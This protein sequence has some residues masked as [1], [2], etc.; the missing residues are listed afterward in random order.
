MKHRGWCEYPQHL[1]LNVQLKWLKL[2]SAGSPLKDFYWAASWLTMDRTYDNLYLY[3]GFS[4]GIFSLQPCHLAPSAWRVILNVWASQTGR[5][6]CP[7]IKLPHTVGKAKTKTIQGLKQP[8]PSWLWRMIL[9]VEV[10]ALHGVRCN[11][12]RPEEVLNELVL[13]PEKPRCS[14]VAL[15]AKQAVGN[16]SWM[17]LCQQ[18][19]YCPSF[20][21]L[22]TLSSCWY[23]DLLTQLCVQVLPKPPQ[24][25]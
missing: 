18:Q 4:T 12:K 17:C 24:W 11:L 19:M 3:Q 25:K 22:P 9:S 8:W 15:R 6:F 10:S 5:L 20:S 1:I 16:I 7:C 2:F 13:L 21:L 14:S 23:S